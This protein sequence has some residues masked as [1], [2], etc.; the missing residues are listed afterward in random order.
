ME[1]SEE[2][3]KILIKEIIKEVQLDKEPKLTLTI[4]EANKLSGIGRDK[5]LELAHN[6]KSNFPCFKNGNKFLINRDKLVS[7]LN[8]ISE[9]RIII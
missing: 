2:K 1:I 3:F 7:W 8:E 4:E 9:K 5:L 6:P